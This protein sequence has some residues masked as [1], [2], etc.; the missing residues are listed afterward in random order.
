MWYI[1]IM[2]HDLTIKWSTEMRHGYKPEIIMLSKESW[3]KKPKIVW[4]HYIRNVQDRQ[5]HINRNRFV[6]ARGGRRANAN[7]YK[8]SF[9]NDGNILQLQC[10]V[11]YM[12]KGLILCYVN[13]ISVKIVEKIKVEEEERNGNGSLSFPTFLLLF[14]TVQPSIKLKAVSWVPTWLP[15]ITT[16][17]ASTSSFV[18]AHLWHW[19]SV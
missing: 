6:V 5:I 1:Y 12:S 2:E 8:V 16:E 9:W 17:R 11:L 19:F 15:E 18:G 13:Y 7:G 10:G 4:F 3:T 14:Q